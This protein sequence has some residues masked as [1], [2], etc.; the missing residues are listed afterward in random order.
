MARACSARRRAEAQ[1][2]G[3]VWR[4]GSLAA[5]ALRTARRAPLRQ[6]QELATRAAEVATCVTARRRAVRRACAAARNPTATLCPQ[7]APP[8][9]AAREQAARIIHRKA[10]LQR[11]QGAGSR[12]SGLHG[13]DIVAEREQV[14]QHEA[15]APGGPR[16]QG[17]TGIGRQRAARNCWAR[18]RALPGL[19]SSLRRMVNLIA[20]RVEL[21]EGGQRSRGMP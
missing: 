1:P 19:R 9:R 18:I 10:A 20:A 13:E 11:I 2:A 15:R 8:R 14:G 16:R 3:K 21:H 7:A 17:P 5:H 12:L 6:A 4:V